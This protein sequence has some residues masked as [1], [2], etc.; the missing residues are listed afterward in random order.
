MNTMTSKKFPFPPVQ[1]SGGKKKYL[2]IAEVMLETSVKCGSWNWQLVLLLYTVYSKV[3]TV[4]LYTV[5][6]VQSP[7]CSVQYSVYSQTE[8]CTYCTVGTAIPHLLA[9]VTLHTLPH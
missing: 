7:C 9:V 2:N 3:F 1:N 5:D 4:Q 8:H 6:L